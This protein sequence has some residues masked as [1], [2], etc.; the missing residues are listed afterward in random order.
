MSASIIIKAKPY[1][2]AL[3]KSVQKDV[4]VVADTVACNVAFVITITLKIR[5]SSRLA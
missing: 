2:N 4:D 3:N 5:E 1:F